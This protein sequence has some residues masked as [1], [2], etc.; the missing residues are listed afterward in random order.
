M[1]PHIPQSLIN[2]LPIM[3]AS[4]YTFFG[5]FVQRSCYFRWYFTMLNDEQQIS[6]W[7]FVQWELFPEQVFN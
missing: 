4:D 6:G 2:E 5:S 3:K 1:K 7:A